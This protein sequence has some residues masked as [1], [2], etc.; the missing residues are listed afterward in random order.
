MAIDESDKLVPKPAR[1]TCCDSGVTQ[2]VTS[3]VHVVYE[4]LNHVTFP[5][6]ASTAI[7]AARSASVCA[8]APLFSFPPPLFQSCCYGGNVC[9]P[10]TLLRAVIK[11]HLSSRRRLAQDPRIF[12]LPVSGDKGRVVTPPAI[13]VGSYHLLLSSVLTPS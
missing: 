5:Q 4:Q 10:L 1:S 9:H 12:P 7:K 8:A 2:S 11:S 13:S 3:P 6:H